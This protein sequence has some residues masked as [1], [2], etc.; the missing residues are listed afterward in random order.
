MPVEKESL[1]TATRPGKGV[2]EELQ[3]ERRS[4]A[5]RALIERLIATVTPPARTEDSE[6]IQ[7]ARAFLLGSRSTYGQ[8]GL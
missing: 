4:K 7:T 6:S 3:A 8:I 1:M 2:A 5:L